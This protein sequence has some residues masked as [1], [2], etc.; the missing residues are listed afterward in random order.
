MTDAIRQL[1]LSIALVA[2]PVAADQGAVPPPPDPAST[3]A[4][5]QQPVVANAASA[6][7]EWR[8]DR[9]FR[10]WGSGSSDSVDGA[11][12]LYEAIRTNGDA[13]FVYEKIVDFLG[14]NRDLHKAVPWDPKHGS[15]R[16]SYL[17][18]ASYLTRLR[19]RDGEALAGAQ[20]QWRASQGTLLPESGAVPC[21]EN[22]QLILPALPDHSGSA[23]ATVEVTA[24]GSLG[25]APAPAA[26]RVLDR[27]I[28]SLGDS[29]AS[30][31]GNPDLPANLG[32]LAGGPGS[33]WSDA[34]RQRWL[35][36]GAMTGV[37]SPSWLDTPCHRSFYN[38]H[39][40]AAL[41]YAADR[42]HEAVTFASYACSGAAI[43]DGLLAP[44]AK[45]PGYYDDPAGAGPELPQVEALA[46]D[47]CLPAS[48]GR[49]GWQLV[50]QYY[51]KVAGGSAERPAL[52]SVRSSK[53]VCSTSYGRSPDALLLTIGGND[54][55]F[56]KIIMWALLPKTMENGRSQA[57]LSVLRSLLTTDPAS[58]GPAIRVG[59]PANLAV[60]DSRLRQVA[61]AAHIFQSAYPAPLYGGDGS[62]CG[63]ED[64]ARPGSPKEAA[65]QRLQAPVG[66][67][68]QTALLP[69]NG[70]TMSIDRSEGAITEAQVIN[71]LNRTIAE[72][73]ASRPHWRLVG[74]FL[75]DF[76]THGWCA[77]DALA[78]QADLP[79]WNSANSVWEPWKPKDW[80]AYARR[81]RYFRTPN[82]TALTLA[83]EAISRR[84]PP[85][86]R[87]EAR[88]RCW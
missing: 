42:P 34:W 76:R 86:P 9:R 59:L 14:S 2:T 10:L 58:A 15:Y 25:P 73:A 27:L 75:G 17:F 13:E 46:R 70:W 23:A 19:L 33:G 71:P 57:A 56:A 60:F 82:D 18:P 49:P 79:D 67:W 87:A 32:M 3:I 54:A 26:V 29:F 53:I 68:P 20:C 65:L 81:S 43:F 47:L 66:L 45:P 36:R 12:K 16:S 7:I 72:A 21:T 48:G 64:E 4:S 80:Q 41:K 28:V 6:S 85:A 84:R 22:V 40:V 63:P 31:E 24:I 62:L 78:E 52:R 11:E 37:R 5:P 8:V 44:Q 69:E 51:T 30:G 83:L 38:Q 61:P 50:R 77:G 74:D 88:R 39:L 1:A 35:A 55:G